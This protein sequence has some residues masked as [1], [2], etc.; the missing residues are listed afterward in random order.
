MDRRAAQL[1][2]HYAEHLGRWLDATDPARQFTLRVPH[3]VSRCTILLHAVVCFA[4]HHLRDDDIA[5]EAYQACPALII[6]RLNLNTALHDDD[7]LCAVVILCFFEQLNVPSSL[8][9]DQKQRLAEVSAILRSSQTTT[10][11][12]SAPTLR[13]AAFW[14]H[15]RQCLYNATITQQPPNIDFSL[16]LHPMAS[17]MTKHHPLSQ[18]RLET[19][20]TNEMTWNC[21]RIAHFCFDRNPTEDPTLRMQ[22]WQGLWDDIESWKL[23]RPHSFEPIWS[24]PNVNSKFPEIYF[25]ADWHVV[26]LGYY[27]VCCILLLT[28]KPDLKSAV[29]FVGHKLSDIDNRV[30]EHAR[31]I[32]GSCK[33]LPECI[34]CLISFCPTIFIWGPLLSDQEE[35]SE[36]LEILV[37][38]ERTQHWP[39]EWIVNALKLE[40]DVD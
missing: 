11:D 36:V 31:A 35:R 34:T 21:A 38:L 12:P 29:R 3:Q 28:Y 22:Q 33:S 15:V 17:A 24:G 10:V 23:N 1:V 8:G 2:H 9:V 37:T 27:H 26:A 13:E 5:E 16:R 30:L 19:A 14:V 7:L 40:W 32:C 4:A 6:E 18:L 20:W 25:T 39:T